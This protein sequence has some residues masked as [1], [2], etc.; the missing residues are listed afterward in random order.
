[1]ILKI[2][3]FVVLAFLLF[4]FMEHIVIPVLALLLKKKRK[5]MTGRSGLIGEVCEVKEWN[6]KEGRGFIHG[7]LWWATSDEPLSPG[8]KAVVQ[9][10]QGLILTV[11]PYK[12]INL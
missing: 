11:E 2:F 8:D 3:L 10:V 4:E 6:N 9:S 12:K 1:M 5:P 7:E